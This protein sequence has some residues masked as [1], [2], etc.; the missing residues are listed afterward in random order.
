MPCPG[1]AVVA[2]PPGKLRQTR[3]E[4]RDLVQFGAVP[5]AFDFKVVVDL[6][7]DPEALVDAQRPGQAQRSIDCDGT[8]P[9]NEFA[10]SDLRQA[11]GLGESV[12]AD[13]QWFKELGEQDLAR[14][15]RVVCGGHGRAP[16]SGS[17]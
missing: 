15:D 12:L 10:D 8:L 17:S 3:N 1:G 4:P 14:G 9:A 16:V 11:S 7:V 6:D 2:H 5:V 13:A